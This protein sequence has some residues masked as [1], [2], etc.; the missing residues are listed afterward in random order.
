MA[1]LFVSDLH[2]DAERPAITELFGRFLAEEARGAEA[3]YILGDLFEA[4]VGDDDPSEVGAFVADRLAALAQAG[5]PSYFI[6]GNR[7][8]LLATT[9]PVA[10]ACA[11]SP[12]RPS[13]SWKARRRS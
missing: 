7:D 1:T 5:T 12:T 10:R 13:S 3:L 6:R 8:F 4:W 11:S 9:T 2:L